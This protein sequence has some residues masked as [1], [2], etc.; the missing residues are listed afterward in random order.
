MNFW[1][2]VDTGKVGTAL[3]KPLESATPEAGLRK[4]LDNRY[5]CRHD[6]VKFNLSFGQFRVLEN[7]LPCLLLCNLALEFFSLLV[8][9]LFALPTHALFID[10]ICFR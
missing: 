8:L 5:P 9:R 7:S 3:N 4:L 6:F 2:N 1:K 10:S